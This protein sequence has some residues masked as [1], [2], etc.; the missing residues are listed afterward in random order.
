MPGV[1]I[2]E[3]GFCPVLFSCSAAASR[4]KEPGKHLVDVDGRKGAARP[5]Q[6]AG[7]QAAYVGHRTTDW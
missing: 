2:T 5:H 7:A 1:A 6:R 3:H 4:R